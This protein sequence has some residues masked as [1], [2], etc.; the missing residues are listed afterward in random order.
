MQPTKQ[1]HT[2]KQQA[3]ST[4]RLDKV[5]PPISLP[6]NEVLMEDMALYAD[7]HDINAMFQDYL[8]R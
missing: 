6:T 2:R 4:G 1:V 8:K 7:R 5:V 3:M